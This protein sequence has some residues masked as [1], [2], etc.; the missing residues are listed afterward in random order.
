MSNETLQTGARNILIEISRWS[1]LCLHCVRYWVPITGNAGH[2]TLT[3]SHQTWHGDIPARSR[4]RR[5]RRKP[6]SFVVRFMSYAVI[7]NLHF[8][9]PYILLNWRWLDFRWL[10]LMSQN[11]T[12]LCSLNSL[13]LPFLLSITEK[14]SFMS[15]E[16]VLQPQTLFKCNEDTRRNLLRVVIVFAGQ[17]K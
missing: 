4:A 8:L 1:I 17:L 12:C 13:H 9:L 5:K 10:S 7:M 3:S 11:S 14:V 16:F 2:Y 6:F 15:L